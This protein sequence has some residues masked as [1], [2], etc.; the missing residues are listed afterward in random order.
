MDGRGW[1][2]GFWVRRCLGCLR[3]GLVPQK[4]QKGWPG[5]SRGEGQPEALSDTRLLVQ[6]QRVSAFLAALF[7][8]LNQR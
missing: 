1:G 4:G 5:F 3:V 6:C 7:V 2:P 8:W